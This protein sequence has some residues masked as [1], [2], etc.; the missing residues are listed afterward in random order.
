M[1]H[2]VAPVV[3]NEFLGR[4]RELAIDG[5]LPKWSE[6]FGPHTMRAL[7]PDL[8]ER[9]AIIAELP[10]LPLSYFEQ[11]V[12]MPED[13][14]DLRY[15]YLLLS[16]PYRPDAEIAR[17]RGWRTVEL[18]GKH[19]DIVTRPREVADSLLHILIA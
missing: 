8:D 6:W 19:L 17:S 13:W 1:Q 18:A 11:R 2:A 14:S 15:A 5:R 9:E 16:E 7:V 4:L 3:P 10:Q 12:P